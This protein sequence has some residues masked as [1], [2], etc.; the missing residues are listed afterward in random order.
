MCGRGTDWAGD[1]GPHLAVRG[2]ARGPARGK[3]P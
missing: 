3:R 1:W 2:D